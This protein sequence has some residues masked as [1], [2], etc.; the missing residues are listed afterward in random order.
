MLIPCLASTVW[1]WNRACVTT[2]Y[3]KKTG[4]L[5]QQIYFIYFSII[6]KV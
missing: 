6:N 3:N 5:A 2:V 1:L 4:F